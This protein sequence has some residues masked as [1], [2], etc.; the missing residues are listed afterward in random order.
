MVFFLCVPQLVDRA[1]HSVC[2]RGSCV[3][4]ATLSCGEEE[5]PGG[6]AAPEVHPLPPGSHC[7]LRRRSL[8]AG[9]ERVKVALETDSNS[10]AAAA[11]LSNSLMELE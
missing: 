1:H 8:G 6:R 4:Q 10:A 3:P 2:P 11:P 9:F 7:L 5:I